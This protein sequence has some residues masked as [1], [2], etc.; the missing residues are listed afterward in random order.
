VVLARLSFA[1]LDGLLRVASDFAAPFFARWLGPDE[2]SRAAEWAV[3]I[4][5]SYLLLALAGLRPRRRRPDPAA[6]SP[7]SC[8]P[9]SSPGRARRPRTM[10]AATAAPPERHRPHTSTESEGETMTTIDEPT[11]MRSNTDLIGREDIND[12]ETIFSVVG[13][14]EADGRHRVKDNCEAEFTW[15]YTKG[16]RPK[17]DKLYEKAKRASGRADRLPWRRRSTR[18]PW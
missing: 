10:T 18:R 15:D 11:E 8:Y 12:L 16:A 3:R 4:V 14:Q 2:A 7:P 17:L 13:A 5:I 1:K 9:A 6:S